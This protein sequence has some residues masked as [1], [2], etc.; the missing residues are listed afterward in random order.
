MTTSLRCELDTLG[1]PKA[2]LLGFA[3]AVCACNVLRVV[4]GAL[5]QA[6]RGPAGGAGGVWE[7]SSYAVAVELRAAYDGLA[8]SVPGEV[9]GRL[10]S[11]SAAAFAAWLVGVVP[12]AR[13]ERYRK[14]RRGPKKPVA[15]VKAG[16]RAAHRATFRLLQQRT[17]PP[18]RTPRP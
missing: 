5:E 2:A 4:C 17:K 7:A 6:N 1:Y 12:K 14:S 8:V 13:C 11:W 16:P 15:R 9:W 18:K 3:V 10:G